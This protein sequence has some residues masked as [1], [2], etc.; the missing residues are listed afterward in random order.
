MNKTTLT[1]VRADPELKRETAKAIQDALA[2]AD[3]HTVESIDAL[4]RELGEGVN[5]LLPRP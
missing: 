1:T 2:G 3:L 5:Q 4:L